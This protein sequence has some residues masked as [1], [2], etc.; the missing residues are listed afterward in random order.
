MFAISMIWSAVLMWFSYK[1][2][3]DPI[4][5]AIATAFIL[6]AMVSW[7]VHYRKVEELENKVKELE[8]KQNSNQTNAKKEV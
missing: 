3:D 7:A 2:T 5:C 1:D 4:L 8:T 6:L